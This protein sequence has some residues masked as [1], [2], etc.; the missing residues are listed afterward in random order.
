MEFYLVGGKL[1]LLI[2]IIKIQKWMKKILYKPETKL[3]TLL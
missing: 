1:R 2:K 3:G